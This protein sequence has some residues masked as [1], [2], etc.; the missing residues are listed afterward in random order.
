VRFWLN[1]AWT[2][3]GRC[4]KHLAT[5]L[6]QFNL[7]SLGSPLI[8]LACVNLLTPWFGVSYLIANSLG[9]AVGLVWNWGWANVVWRSSSRTETASEAP[10]A[11]TPAESHR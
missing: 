10:K 6:Y 4:R 3:R 5:R 9:I 11:L 2:F 8:A 7:S 1:D